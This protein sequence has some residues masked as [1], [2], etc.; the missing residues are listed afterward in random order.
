MSA[1]GAN[2]EWKR[3]VPQGLAGRI[4]SA[5]TKMRI[6]MAFWL[7]IGSYSLVTTFMG[8]KL[9][10]LGNLSIILAL[11][12]QVFTMIYALPD[13]GM[14][15]RF[16]FGASIPFWLILCIAMHGV[17]FC[18]SAYYHYMLTMR[19]MDRTD[20]ASLEETKVLEDS[21]DMLRFNTYDYVRF[22]D[23]LT[24]YYERKREQ[25]ETGKGVSSLSGQGD[26]Y[27]LFNNVVSELEAQKS[28]VFAEDRVDRINDLLEPNV[29][30]RAYVNGLNKLSASITRP[31]S[32]YRDIIQ[33]RLSLKE[34]RKETP[35]FDYARG[36][37]VLSPTEGRKIIVA[38]LERYPFTKIDVPHD[39]KSTGSNK[40]S[41]LKKALMLEGL[42]D[43]KGEF[44]LGSFFGLFAAT[45]VE[46][47]MFVINLFFAAQSRNLKVLKERIDRSSM[48]NCAESEGRDVLAWLSRVTE[49]AKALKPAYPVT[50]LSMAQDSIKFNC[51]RNQ[52]MLLTSLTARR[53]TGD[54]ARRLFKRL[55]IRW[56]VGYEAVYVKINKQ[57]L[58]TV[59][60]S[61]DPGC[62][63]RIFFMEKMQE[64]DREVDME[65][66]WG[67][68]VLEVLRCIVKQLL[69]SGEL[70]A[71]DGE[72]WV[73]MEDFTNWLSEVEQMTGTL[74][75]IIP[76]GGPMA[77]QEG[78]DQY[79]EEL[80]ED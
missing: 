65:E 56:G 51:D 75:R 38:Y 10:H 25:S 69:K 78:C 37:T 80:K 19:V 40:L 12:S 62:I 35:R 59:N 48:I 50:L 33:A 73:D 20:H 53:A 18:G 57:W 9:S 52:R 43:D 21:Q 64:G 46:I 23:K 61:N 42:K 76:R 7:L 70:V 77:M 22:L 55:W 14:V 16:F 13:V 47:A 24:A 68:A 27:R 29:E 4:A 6:I 34:L 26:R 58:E 3:H 28:L 60:V 44:D 1:N 74:G 67:L 31:E 32:S 8:Y 72:Y 71:V 66:I 49:M 5:Q 54:Y 17:S 2:G 63:G 45:I 41:G 39:L 30:I 15:K 36:E 79:K 11:A